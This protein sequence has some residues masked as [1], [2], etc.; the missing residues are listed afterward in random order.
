MSSRIGRAWRGVSVA[1][2]WLAVALM[3]TPVSAQVRNAGA[4][5]DGRGG[6]TP[7][8]INDFQS[9]ALRSDGEAECWGVNGASGRATPPMGPF[10]ALS[11]A[12]NYTCAL[13]GDGAAAC[14]GS[15]FSYNARPPAGAFTALASSLYVT[16]A[17]KARTTPWSPLE[18]NVQC[19]NERG[20]PSLIPPAAPYVAITGGSHHFCS[21]TGEGLAD[22]WS[23]GYGN[24]YGQTRPPTEPFVAISAGAW[25]TCGLRANGSV[26][27]WGANDWGQSTPPAERFIAIAAGAF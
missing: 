20:G 19:W 11:N 4:M 3:A 8:G 18:S 12:M 1:C 24:D 6:T 26:A 27:C 17:I 25:F 23:D 2:L 7:L 9:C 16:C 22:C 10:I 21:L 13:R 5:P 15:D 14:W